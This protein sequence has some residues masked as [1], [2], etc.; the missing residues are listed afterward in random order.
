MSVERLCDFQLIFGVYKQPDGRLRKRSGMTNLDDHSASFM[1]LI[2]K[3]FLRIR[4]NDVLLQSSFLIAQ[5]IERSEI[6]HV[7]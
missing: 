6:V 7:S 2:L 1:C 3:S 5:P 4:R